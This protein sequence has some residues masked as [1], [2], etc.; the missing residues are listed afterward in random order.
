MVLYHRIKYSMLWIGFMTSE[1]ITKACFHTLIGE[2]MTNKRDILVC[3]RE[4]ILSYAI[5]LFLSANE[6]WIVNTTTFQEEMNELIA[7][8]E[9][10]QPDIVIIQQDLYENPTSIPFQ[11]LRDHPGITVILV[12][13]ANNLMEI[14][15]KQQVCVKQ[16]SDLI[17]FIE[18]TP[19][20]YLLSDTEL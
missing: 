11:L 18:R 6:D 10:I 7:A 16:V 5:G 3:G 15:S 20:H 2:K 17:S 13:L 19:S 4:D 8:I 14:Y 9:T 1:R 12:S